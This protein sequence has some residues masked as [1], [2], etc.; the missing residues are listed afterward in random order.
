MNTDK[1]KELSAK[2][3]TLNEKYDAHIQIFLDSPDTKYGQQQLGA[4]K[5]MQEDLF[6]IEKELFEFMKV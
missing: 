6:A 1:F 5:Q 2:W 4:M 3:E